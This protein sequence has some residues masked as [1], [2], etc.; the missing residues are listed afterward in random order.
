[1]EEDLLEFLG[2]TEDGVFIIDPDQRII[3]WNQ[4]ARAILGYDANEVLGRHCYE[5]VGGELAGKGHECAQDCNV[6]LLTRQGTV[7]PTVRLAVRTKDGTERW[8]S[9]THISMPVGPGRNKTALVHVFRD[10]S[11]EVEALGLVDGMARYLRDGARLPTLDAS[12]HADSTGAEASL[13][14]REIQVLRLLA[15]GCGTDAIADR[16]VVS[17]S[18]A[19]NH[20]QNILEKLGV[21]SRMEAVMYGIR[22]HM[23]ATQ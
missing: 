10:G 7:P 8:L 3:L 5:I 20:I 15:E 4:G 14:Q 1:M 6:I 23:I 12:A 17:V 22:H 2:N 19:R 13:T 11:R 18:T 21:H 9:M 16:L